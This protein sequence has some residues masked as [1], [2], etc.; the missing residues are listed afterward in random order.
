MRADSGSKWINLKAVFS[1][2]MCF[3]TRDYRG[4][5]INVTKADLVFEYCMKR[6]IA[7]QAVQIHEPFIVDTLEGTHRGDAGDYLMVGVN[8]ERYPCKKEIFEKTYDWVPA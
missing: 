8:G 2:A 1:E 4:I 6:P 5:M 7:V 3:N